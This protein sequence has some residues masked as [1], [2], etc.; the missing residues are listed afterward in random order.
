M[1]FLN[2]PLY[3][4]I[5]SGYYN[6]KGKCYNLLQRI[7]IINNPF[8]YSLLKGFFIKAANKIIY[9][10]LRDSIFPIKYFKN[11]RLPFLYKFNYALL[12]IIMAFPFFYKVLKNKKNSKGNIKLVTRYNILIIIFTFLKKSLVSIILK[13]ISIL[14]NKACIPL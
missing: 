9:K 3:I 13:L 6:I 14:V 11:Y 7:I 2:P 1:A 4:I 5:G 8:N 12:I 10:A